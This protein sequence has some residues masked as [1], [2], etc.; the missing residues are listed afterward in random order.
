MYAAACNMC[1]RSTEIL[2]INTVAFIFKHSQIFWFK[3]EF[4]QRRFETAVLLPVELQTLTEM[5]I[6]CGNIFRS[7]WGWPYA[8]KSLWIYCWFLP[9]VQSL[10][11]HTGVNIYSTAIRSIFHT[12]NSVLSGI[13]SLLFVVIGT[14]VLLSGIS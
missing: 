10:F 1:L 4:H 5:F 6:H 13:I 12:A 11:L 2:G 7:Q 8:A 9:H 3:T 14:A